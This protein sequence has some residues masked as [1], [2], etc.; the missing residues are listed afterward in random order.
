VVAS[1][2]ARVPGGIDVALVL[3]SGL[4]SFADR[5]EDRVDVPYSEVEDLPTSTVAG[6]AGRYVFGRRGALRLGVMQGRVHL[7]EGWTPEEVVRPVRG[8]LGLGAKVLIVTNAAGAVSE[9]VDAGDLVVITDHVNM[10]GR[11][12]LVGPNDSG[13]GPRFPDLQ[14]A[15]DSAL[16]AL[17]HRAASAAGL[18][19]AEGVYGMMLGPSYETPAEIRMLSTLGVDLVGMSTVPE[20]I[21]AR[22]AGVRVLGISCATNRAAGRPGAILDHKDVQAV[23]ARVSRD[24][25]ALLDGVLD[26]LAEQGTP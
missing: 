14:N 18:S 23:A 4:G 26:G 19:L 25:V 20:V 21:A 8:L 16:R 5:L 9:A 10:S 3:G 24:F 22:H 1:R 6:H 12:P 2:G 17:A 13:L 7:Y 15:Y 11:N